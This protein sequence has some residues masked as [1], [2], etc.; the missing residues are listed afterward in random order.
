MGDTWLTWENSN[1]IAGIQDD[2]WH[3]LAFV[4]DATTSKMTLYV[5]GVANANVPQWG[6]HGDANLDDSK[7]TNLNIGGRPTKDLGWGREW[8]GGI[9][10]VRLYSKALSA[11]EAAALYN[12][13]Q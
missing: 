9:D 2:K 4:Y 11:S 5:D 3:H 7:V 1:K 12:A 6:T 8:T 13:K 10:Q